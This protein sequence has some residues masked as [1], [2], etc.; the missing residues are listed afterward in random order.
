MPT[1]DM[2]IGLYYLTHRKP[3]EIGEGLVFSSDAEARMAYDAKELHLQAPIR[4]RVA[5]DTH[6]K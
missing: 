4:V 3:G 5:G 6:V 2:I 1:Q